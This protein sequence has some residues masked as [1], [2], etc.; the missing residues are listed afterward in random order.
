MLGWGTSA[1]RHA[2][3]A[4]N[5]KLF[6]ALVWNQSNPISDIKTFKPSHQLSFDLKYFI[7]LS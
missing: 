2:L 1:C 3:R 6:N 4:R 5:D 7:P